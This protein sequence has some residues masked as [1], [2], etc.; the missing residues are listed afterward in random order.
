MISRS[1]GNAKKDFIQAKISGSLVHT[2]LSPIISYSLPHA[3]AGIQRRQAIA[4]GF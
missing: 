2:T 4:N 3:S 1:Y